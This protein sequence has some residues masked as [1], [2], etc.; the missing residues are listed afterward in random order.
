MIDV[1]LALDV[2]D[3]LEADDDVE[4][5]VIE[6]EGVHVADGELERRMRLCTRRPRRRRRRRPR[7]ASTAPAAASIPGAVSESPQPAS[8]DTPPRHKAAGATSIAA[9][10]LGPP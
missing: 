3:D 10:V 4:A 2:L 8:S 7:A 1:V 9:E 5:A 6:R